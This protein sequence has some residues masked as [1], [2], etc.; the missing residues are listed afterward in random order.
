MRRHATEQVLKALA[1]IVAAAFAIFP[2]LGNR[3]DLAIP[4]DAAT[5]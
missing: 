5:R 1:A 4:I 2:I 3:L